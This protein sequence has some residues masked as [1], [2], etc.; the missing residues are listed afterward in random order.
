MALVGC[1]CS[2]GVSKKLGPY[3]ECTVRFDPPANEL[4]SLNVNQALGVLTTDNMQVLNQNGMGTIEVQ[5]TATGQVLGQGQFGYY[6]V[7]DAMYAQNPAAVHDWLSTFSQYGYTAVTV[8]V[9]EDDIQ[10]QPTITQGTATLGMAAQYQ[11]FTYG[12]GTLIEKIG[13]NSCP[14]NLPSCQPK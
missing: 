9:S 7:N 13:S 2:V 4:A 1:T 6:I 3:A 12:S 8:T 11:G 14:P 10:A 5:D